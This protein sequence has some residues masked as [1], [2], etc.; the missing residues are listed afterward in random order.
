MVIKTKQ[1]YSFKLS[2]FCVTVYTF[3][4]IILLC[5]LIHVQFIIF[6]AIQFCRIF[7][8]AE[9]HGKCFLY[10]LCGEV[11]P[12]YYLLFIHVWYY[13]TQSMNSMSTRIHS[14]CV[15]FQWNIPIFQTVFMLSIA[16]NRAEHV[17]VKPY[18]TIFWYSQI[19]LLFHFFL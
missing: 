9:Y 7:A 4:H 18:R 15:V 11:H 10:L 5:S 8:A 16:I 2:S 17:C 3:L 12:Y 13:T 6:A 14:I 19:P 1:F